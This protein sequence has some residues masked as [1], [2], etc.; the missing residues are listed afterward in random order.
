MAKVRI[1]A[2]SADVEDADE[3]HLPPPAA[4]AYHHAKNKHIGAL[5][6]L[7]R[8]WKK[9]GFVGWYQVSRGLASSALPAYG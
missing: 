2:R 4:H 1:Q 8:A 3:H 9:E 5:E 7:A 6:I